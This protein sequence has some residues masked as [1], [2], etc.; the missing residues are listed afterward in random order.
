MLAEISDSRGVQC[1]VSRDG[2]PEPLN[3]ARKIFHVFF[4]LHEVGH[5]RFKH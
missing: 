1:L 3:Q 4:L 2:V 5:I